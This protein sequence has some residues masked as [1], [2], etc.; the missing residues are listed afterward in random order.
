MATKRTTKTVD[1]GKIAWRYAEL[2]KK[3]VYREADSKY[4]GDELEFPSIEEQDQWTHSEY[5]SKVMRALNWYNATQ[6]YKTAYS[7]LSLFLARNPRRARLAELAKDGTLRTG[8]TIG[9]ITR[10]G[11][12]GLKLRFHTL[13][14]I[15]KTIRAAE[16]D[17]SVSGF[18]VQGAKDRAKA[19]AEALKAKAPTIQDRL[20]EKT[21]ECAGEIEGR[22][23]EFMT[24]NEFK[25]EPRA[26]DLLVQYNIQP[27]HMKTI[28]AL[29]EKRIAEYND[30]IST[31]DSQTIEA[32]KHLGKRQ[33]TAVVK[34]WTQV[35]AD[36]NSYG[37]IKKASKAPRKKKAVPPEKIVAKMQHLKEFAELKL[38]SA[39][40]TTILT[41]QELWV[42]NT[43]TRKLGIYIVDQYA[44]AL[45]VKGTAIQ[46]FDAAASV[47][48]TLRKPAE[49]LKEFSANGKP[50][51]KK[52]FKTIKA[53]ETKLN[54]RINKD[55]ILLK[56]YK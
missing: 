38:K 47:Q 36:C 2:P 29:V 34:W 30:I 51:A 42:Y 39:D 11:R 55:M 49:Q 18:S 44:G 41:A 21:A 40:A 12:V 48:K 33:L 35:L 27:A 9:F 23:D 13:R 15:V 50:A 46:G 52:W 22:F 43:K 24:A 53:T 20:A 17:T 45:G 28:V 1:S 19:E 25:G 6:D 10:A 32:Y 37:V 16:N 56:V 26:V 3:L 5:T 31:N 4:I 14:T 8:P 54:G 7:W